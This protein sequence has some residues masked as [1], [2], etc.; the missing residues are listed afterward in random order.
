MFICL[1]LW[2]ND[3]KTGTVPMVTHWSL[4]SSLLSHGEWTTQTAEVHYNPFCEGSRLLHSVSFPQKHIQRCWQ[5]L[6]EKPFKS[7]STII[8]EGDFEWQLRYRGRSTKYGVRSPT[9]FRASLHHCWC[10]LGQGVFI[11]LMKASS[12]IQRR[13]LNKCVIIVFAHCCVQS[14]MERDHQRVQRS[15]RPSLPA[16]SSL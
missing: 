9:G 15:V 4:W 1:G 16:G 3:Y 2:K 7:C 13:V 6:K 14:A 8:I 12:I 5:P 11:F 10:D